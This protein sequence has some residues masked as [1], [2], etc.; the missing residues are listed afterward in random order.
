MSI[1]N[2]VYKS[3]EINIGSPEFSFCFDSSNSLI[4]MLIEIPYQ[5]M[6]NDVTLRNWYSL[7]ESSIKKAITNLESLFSEIR[8]RHLPRRN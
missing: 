8:W 1:L 4:H 2:C 5:N 7:Y 3:R 6:Y